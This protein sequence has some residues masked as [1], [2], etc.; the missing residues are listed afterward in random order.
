MCCT[1]HAKEGELLNRF[2]RKA[3]KVSTILRFAVSPE[4]FSS[5]WRALS[6]IAIQPPA[7]C[8]LCHYEGQFRSYGGDNRPRAKCPRCQSLERHR[9]LALAGI[10]FEGRDVLHF[11]PERPVSKFVCAAAPASY[12]TSDI[13][14]AKRCDRRFNIE[15]IDSADAAYDIILCSHVLEHVDDGKALAELNRVLRPGGLLVA[16]VPLVEGWLQTYEDASLV[17]HRDRFIH[18]GQG[19]HV[20]FFGADFRDR[21]RNAGFL[22]DEFTASGPDS[23]KYALMRGEKVF[24]CAKTDVVAYSNAETSVEP[25]PNRAMC[26]V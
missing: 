11:A 4:G 17:S 19:E 10:D 15:A 20:R 23:V 13:D 5:A 22:V 6:I 2:I 25:S 18:Y 16:M 9:L 3:K 21:V 7:T 26:D 14:P 8:N 1:A 12:E 24:L